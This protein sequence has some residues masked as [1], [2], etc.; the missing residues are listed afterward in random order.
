M[1]KRQ[2]SHFTSYYS[3][4]DKFKV[5]FD[6]LSKHAQKEDVCKRFPFLVVSVVCIP[7]RTKNVIPFRADTSMNL[8]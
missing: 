6:K 5:V 2:V 8:T 1:K 7:S 4:V 3:M